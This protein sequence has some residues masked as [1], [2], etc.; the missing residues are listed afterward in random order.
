MPEQLDLL[1][2]LQSSG[3]KESKS[4]DIN[5]VVKVPNAISEGQEVLPEGKAVGT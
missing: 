1:I 5:S 4:I 3:G 2:N